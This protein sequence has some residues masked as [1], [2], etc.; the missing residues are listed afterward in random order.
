[1][2]SL[3]F[4]THT[5]RLLSISLPKAAHLQMIAFHKL[6][7]GALAQACSAS[8]RCCSLLLQSVGLK[9]PLHKDAWLH[10]LRALAASGAAGQAAGPGAGPKAQT[11][12]LP[13]AALQQVRVLLPSWLRTPM[14]LSL[15]PGL[16][17]LPCPC[18]HCSQRQG[19]M[20]GTGSGLVGMTAPSSS[21]SELTD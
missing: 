19:D 12:A 9:A 5:P 17:H 6:H 8:G 11:E 14:R 1:M 3:N 16:Q 13:A 7:L 20:G 15:I 2:Q 21:V 4:C 18:A 10:A